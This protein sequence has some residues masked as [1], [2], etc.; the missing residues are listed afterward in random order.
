MNDLSLILNTSGTG[1][2]IGNSVI[3]H[4]MDADDLV[5]LSP[6]SAGLQQLL[7]ICSMYGAEFDIKYNAKKSKIMIVRSREDKKSKFPEFYLSGVILG[8]CS[9]RLS[10]ASH[11]K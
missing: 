11:H 9:D 8:A 1:C 3:N 6:Y 2:R 4:L 7:A 10:G 5:I